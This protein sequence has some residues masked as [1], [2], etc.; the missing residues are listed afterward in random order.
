MNKSPRKF[1]LRIFL[2]S[3]MIAAAIHLLFGVKMKEVMR[4]LSSDKSSCRSSG[5]DYCV[6][7]E[8]RESILLLKHPLIV[9]AFPATALIVK[10]YPALAKEGTQP[11]FP[12]FLSRLCQSIGVGLLV[13]FLGVRF[14]VFQFRKIYLPPL[15]SPY[16]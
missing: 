11:L 5:I 15:D 9:I 13:G 2:L 12:S 16:R 14:S 1:D 10:L 4:F 8:A 7:D 3:S 6:D